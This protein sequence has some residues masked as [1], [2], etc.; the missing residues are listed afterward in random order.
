[1]KQA[2]SGTAEGEGEGGLDANFDVTSPFGF[3]RIALFLQSASACAKPVQS[4][5]QQACAHRYCPSVIK[6]KHSLEE[7]KQ[8]SCKA[9]C[10]IV[11]RG[12]CMLC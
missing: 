2:D 3:P 10:G 8:R 5:L 11:R 7:A 1:M 12:G 9:A 4:S 6:L